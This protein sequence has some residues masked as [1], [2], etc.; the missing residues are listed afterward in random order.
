MSSVSTGARTRQWLTHSHD[1]GLNQGMRC[2]FGGGFACPLRSIV[3]KV[4]LSP[5][6][7]TTGQFF[8][9]FWHVCTFICTSVFGCI[10]GSVWKPEADLP[11]L[12]RHSPP[13][14]WTGSFTFTWNIL[15][16]LGWMVSKLQ[17]S[18]C[19]CF[20]LLGLQ[21]YTII[22]S[23]SL[24]TVRI[25]LRSPCLCFWF[26]VWLWGGGKCFHVLCILFSVLK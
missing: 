18:S 5:Q 24:Q 11:C 14:L 2:D 17:R 10:C 7:R 6:G 15:T 26:Q 3:I 13:C 9:L 23:L 20:P 21:A 1:L 22:S 4:L 16:W 25:E 8:L 12:L 19:L